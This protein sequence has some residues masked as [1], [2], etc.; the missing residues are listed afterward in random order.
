MRLKTA[1]RSRRTLYDEVDIDHNAPTTE[2]VNSVNG[3]QQDDPDRE[4][5]RSVDI[6]QTRA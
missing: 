2:L 4:V 6:D 1:A 5:R 3:Q